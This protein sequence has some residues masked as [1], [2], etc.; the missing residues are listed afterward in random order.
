MRRED[1]KNN[2]ILSFVDSLNIIDDKKNELLKELANKYY[3]EDLTTLRE[4]NTA[5]IKNEDKW[6]CEKDDISFVKVQ[7]EFDLKYN[8]YTYR[9][10]YSVLKEAVVGL[11]DLC[12]S[13]LP[14][15]SVVELKKEYL[16]K[17]M[18]GNEV[19]KA[20]FVIISRF[21]CSNNSNIYFNYSGVI[22]PFGLM[23]DSKTLQFT[24]T[25]IKDVIQEGYADEKE[26]AYVYLL[27]KELIVDK[28]MHSFGLATE[29]EINEFKVGLEVGE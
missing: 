28:K 7:D 8:D 5:L 18:N 6:N 2:L 17:V 29:E 4:L 26:D 3:E 1:L 20:I 14:I 12:E 11:I 19:E 13:V 25:L 23:S 16:Q 9:F 22:Y 27:K 15:G 21:I 24:S 10:E